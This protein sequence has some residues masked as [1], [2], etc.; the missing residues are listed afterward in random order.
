LQQFSLCG[1]PDAWLPSVREAT[2]RRALQ[3]SIQFWIER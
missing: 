2:A 3:R 1:V